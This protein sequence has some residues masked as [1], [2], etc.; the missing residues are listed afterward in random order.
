MGVA[1]IA[2]AANENLQPITKE[3]LGYGRKLANE[4]GEELSVI[5]AGEEIAV[6]AKEAIAFGADKV[7]TLEDPLLKEYL[8]ECYLPAMIK[9]IEQALPVFYCLVKR[10][11]EKN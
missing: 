4:L 1:I 8:A 2:E 7:Y 3:L 9:A 6:L 5:I 11:Q 10:P